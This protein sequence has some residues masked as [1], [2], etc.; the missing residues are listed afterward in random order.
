MTLKLSNDYDFVGNREFCYH[1]FD[2]D[3]LMKIYESREKLKAKGKP[4]EP[5]LII[6]D[7]IVGSNNIHTSPGFMKLATTS[8]HL[9]SRLIIS[10]QSY[11]TIPPVVREQIDYMFIGYTK[12]LVIE[13]LLKKELDLPKFFESLDI[14]RSEKV[15]LF[16]KYITKLTTEHYFLN[17]YGYGHTWTKYKASIIPE[18]FRVFF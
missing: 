15:K 13:D 17:Y 14:K 1:E 18:T 2:S 6:L 10:A 11:K 3:K 8:R 4:L 5:I 16:M 9:N 7:D 12:N